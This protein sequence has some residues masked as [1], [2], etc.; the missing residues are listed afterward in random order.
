MSEQRSSK[1]V[2]DDR[3]PCPFCGRYGLRACQEYVGDSS[4]EGK[5]F[6]ECMFCDCCGPTAETTA[7]AV[8]AWNRRPADETTAPQFPCDHCGT[9]G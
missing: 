6:V 4:A 1:E 8:A 3:K 5:Y 7:L 9:E 2:A